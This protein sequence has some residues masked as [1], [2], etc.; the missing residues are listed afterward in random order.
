MTNGPTEDTDK[1]YS[2]YYGSLAKGSVIVYV[3]RQKDTEVVAEHLTAS[4]VKGGV[5]VYHGGMDSTAR[6]KSQSMVCIQRRLMQFFNYRIYSDVI[7]FQTQV[8]EGQG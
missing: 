6:T 7:A 5:V 2:Q 3:W 1:T 4:G 8:H